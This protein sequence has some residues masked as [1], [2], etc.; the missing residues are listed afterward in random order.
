MPGTFAMVHLPWTAEHGEWDPPHYFT[1]RMAKGPAGAVGAPARLRGD[2][3]RRHAH[4]GQGHRAAAA[5][6]GGQAQRR[7]E[8]VMTPQPTGSSP[9]GERQLKRRTSRSTTSTT[10]PV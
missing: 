1:D 7:G 2:G 6:V 9:T 8:R 10:G 4:P 5:A 3:G